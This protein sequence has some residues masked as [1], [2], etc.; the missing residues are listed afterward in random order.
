MLDHLP[1]SGISSRPFLTEWGEVVSETQLHGLCLARPHPKKAVPPT[2]V[3][4][5]ALHTAIVALTA[6]ISALPTPV[7]GMCCTTFRHPRPVP[8]LQRSAFIF[9]Y[10]AFDINVPYV[11]NVLP[12]LLRL[13]Q[14]DIFSNLYTE[15]D[16]IAVQVQFAPFCKYSAEYVPTF[17]VLAFVINICFVWLSFIP[18][19][20]EGIFTPT[21]Y[22]H[23]HINPAIHPKISP[24]NPPQTT[25]SPSPNPHRSLMPPPPR[26]Q[27]PSPIGRPIEPPP[28]PL[29]PPQTAPHVTV[30]PRCRQSPGPSR[31]RRRLKTSHPPRV[32]SRADG[33][34]HKKGSQQ[35]KTL[36][37]GSF[38]EF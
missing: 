11:A 14:R 15:V 36:S 2:P 25:G 20:S 35:N 38:S 21:F 23:R 28:N 6:A 7:L 5:T 32:C 1:N 24:V 13:F 31:R 33:T 18:S 10:G 37:T 3:R 26:I 16:D 4:R 8:T 22:T 30:T 29:P 9:R 34:P 19:H 12:P 17:Q 27:H